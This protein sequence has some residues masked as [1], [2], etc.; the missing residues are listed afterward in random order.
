MTCRSCGSRRSARR[1]LRVSCL[2]HEDGDRDC[3][4]AFYVCRPS[5]N[6]NRPNCIRRSVL[7]ADIHRLELAG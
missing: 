1:M 5:V 3:I 6:G 4:G 7:G 2:I